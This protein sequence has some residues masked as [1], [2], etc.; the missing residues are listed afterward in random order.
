[1]DK[2]RI[3]DLLDQLSPILVG[4]E[5]TVGKKLTEKL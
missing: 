2:Q 1:M 5:E 3:I 4:K